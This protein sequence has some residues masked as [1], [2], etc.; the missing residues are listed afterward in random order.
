MFLHAQ[1]PP[2]PPS[3]PEKNPPPPSTPPVFLFSCVVT[4]EEMRSTLARMA[5]CA[6]HSLHLPRHD[7]QIIIRGPTDL[8]PKSDSGCGVMSHDRSGKRLHTCRLR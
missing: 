6:L 7:G 4:T 3:S 1:A 5:T 2:P 8:H